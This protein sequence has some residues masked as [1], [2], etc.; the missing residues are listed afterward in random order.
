MFITISITNFK[1]NRKKI[2]ASKQTIL[3]R[4]CKSVRMLLEL[5]QNNSSKLK[6]KY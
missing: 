4:F 1:L 6:K 3:L 5:L 2:K